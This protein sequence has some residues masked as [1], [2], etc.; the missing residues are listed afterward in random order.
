MREILFRGKDPETGVWYEGQY[1]HLHK[2]TYC[3]SGSEE[4]DAENEIHQIVFEQMTDWNLPNRHLR[5][6]VLP[7]TVG[8]FTGR[9]DKNGKRIFEGDIVEFYFFDKTRRNGEL[10]EVKNTKTM[11]IV[12]AEQSFHMKELFRNYR[13]DKELGIIT[14]IIY[15][16]RGDRRQGVYQT[17]E[18]YFVEVIGNAHDNPELLE[19]ET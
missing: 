14:E 10:V 1:I 5:A 17:N 13:L 11:L 8:Q 19:V 18:C 7:E 3:F 9:T 6:D 2:T 15:E 16:Y 12:W 4:R